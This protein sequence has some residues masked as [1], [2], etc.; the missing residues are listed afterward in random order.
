MCAVDHSRVRVLIWDDMLRGV[1]LRRCIQPTGLTQAVEPVVWYYGT[2]A[3]PGVFVHITI[4]NSF[5]NRR[6]DVVV[7]LCVCVGGNVV[8]GC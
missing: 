1:D 4:A 8:Q 6:V 3:V 5:Y 7:G 2:V